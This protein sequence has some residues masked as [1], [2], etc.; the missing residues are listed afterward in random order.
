MSNI[1]ITATLV[2]GGLMD[3]S[4]YGHELLPKF[5]KFQ[6]KGYK[7]K[8]LIH[9]FITDDWGAPPRFVDVKTDDIDVRIMYS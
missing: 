4:E 3:F 1:E 6:A 5:L 7:G 2:D 8:S 9:A